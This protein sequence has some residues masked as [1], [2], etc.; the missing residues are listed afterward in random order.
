MVNSI[1]D[2]ALLGAAQ[3]GGT[4]VLPT[5]YVYVGK[6][7]NDTTGNGSANKPYLTVQKAI[8]SSSSGTTIF[9]F[10]G[11][12]SESITF[13]AGV[14]LTSPATL[15]VYITGNHIADF[16]GTVVI[17]NI[18]LNSSSGNTL[19]FSGNGNKNLQFHSSSV[20]STSGHAI[21]W[22]NTNTSSKINFGDCTVNVTTSGSSA[23]AIYS[24]TGAVGGIIANTT[25]FKVNNPNN[26]CLEIGGGVTF[27]HTADVIIGQVVVNNTASVTIGNVSMTTTSVPC[28]VTNS[29][30][31][32]TLLNV[33]AV[34]GGTYAFGGTVGSTIVFMGILYGAVAVGAQNITAIPLYMAPIR[35]R[36]STLY[37]SINTG[38]I[39]FDGNDLYVDIGTKR[40]KLNKTE[41]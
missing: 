32:T 27:T 7:G 30:G 29:S 31:S 9:I 16:S 10:P 18:V 17:E 13:K 24:T 14:N 38:T 23:K 21:N 37:S 12:Y 28:L 2:M 8:T 3:N 36:P 11:T 26:I 40:Y 34:S 20:Y 1:F 33:I 41:V 35:I 15:S 22:T 6:N 25:S 39:Q 4:D 19:L 5:N